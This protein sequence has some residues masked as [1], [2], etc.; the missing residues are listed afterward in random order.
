MKDFE[1][2]YPVEHTDMYLS[3]V[4]FT[5]QVVQ[6][7]RIN[8]PHCIHNSG[9]LGEACVHKQVVTMPKIS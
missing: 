5:L 4:V 8:E 7:P 9:L 3:I 2:P 1:S 6:H